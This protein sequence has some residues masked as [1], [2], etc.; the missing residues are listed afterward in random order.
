MRAKRYGWREI[1]IHF[2]C[3]RTTAWRHWQRATTVADQL[4]GVVGVVIWHDLARMVCNASVRGGHQRFCPTTN[5]TESCIVFI[6]APG[7]GQKK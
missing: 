2:A 6:Y 3:D 5:P 1:T 7:S 4:N